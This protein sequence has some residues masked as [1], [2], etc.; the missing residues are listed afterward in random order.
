MKNIEIKRLVE[1]NLQAFNE[2]IYRECDEYLLPQLES[3]SSLSSIILDWQCT[4]NIKH[5]WSSQ[6]FNRADNDVDLGCPYCLN[7]KV[8]P[9]GPVLLKHHRNSNTIREYVQSIWHCTKCYS[10]WDFKEIE[11]LNFKSI[12]INCETGYEIELLQNQYPELAREWDNDN[13][14]LPSSQVN[15]EFMYD[16]TW[17]CNTCKQQWSSKLH[18]RIH[19]ISHCPYCSGKLPIPDKTSF[20]ALYPEYLSE[21]NWES[22]IKNERDPKK[23]FPNF[24]FNVDWICKICSFPYSLSIIN[25]LSTENSCPNCNGNNPVKREQYDYIKRELYKETD[26]VYLFPKCKTKITWL[27]NECNNLWNSSIYDRLYS[28]KQCPY[29]SLKKALPGK[30]SFKALYPDL[31]SE[32]SDGSNIDL[33]TILPTYTQRLSWTCSKCMIKWKASPKDRSEGTLVCPYCSGEKVIPGKTSFK[34]LHPELMIEWN[35][36]NRLFIDADTILDNYS[37]NVWWR[38]LKCHKSY[39]MSPAVKLTYYK[40]FQESCAYCKGYRK[41]KIHFF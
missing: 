18:E 9:D 10:V 23:L 14:M 7:Q 33:D 29:C 30:T 21:W 8:F 13:N 41:L 19:N 11:T 35:E 16:V 1:T 27:C 25:R 6:V 4:S 12:C 5:I 37:Q 40:R 20:A 17:K 24:K 34:A 15:V 26:K 3:I 36:V 22:N 38:C 32:I 39:E 31:A 28:G 2:I